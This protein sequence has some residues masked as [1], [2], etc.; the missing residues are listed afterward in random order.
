L[1]MVRRVRHLRG[2]TARPA[3]MGLAAGHQIA[4]T[5]SELLLA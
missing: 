1:G 3:G 2:P 4:T 5:T